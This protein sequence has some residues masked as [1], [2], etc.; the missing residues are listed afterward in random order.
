MSSPYLL[1]PIAF[2][3]VFFYLITL[4]LSKLSVIQRSSHRKIWNVILLITFLV[5]AL[6]GLILAVQVNLKLKIPYL[7][8]ILKWHVDFGIGMT[9]VAVFHFIW[10]WSYY[11]GLFKSGKHS[12]IQRKKGDIADSENN[13]I[14][15]NIRIL[16]YRFTAILLGFTTII[17]QLVLL[18]EFM[19]VFGGN[20]LIVGIILANWMIITATGAYLGKLVRI[21]KLSALSLPGAFIFLG[22]LPALTVFLMDYLKNIVFQPGVEFSAIKIVYSAAIVLIPFCLLSGFLFTSIAVLYSAASGRKNIDKI[23]ALES[24]G[25]ILA[26]LIFSYFLAG[27]LTTFQVL[28][29]ILFINVIV[30]AFMI[31]KKIPL[32]VIL[33]MAALMVSI[34]PFLFNADKIIRQYL[35]VNQDL[36][37]LKD[38]PFGN[39]AVTDYGTQQNFYENNVLLFTTEN[40]IANEEAVHYAMIQHPNPKNVLL[41]SGG[42]SG[43]TNEILKYNIKKLDYVEL[44]PWIFKLGLDYTSSLNSP[45]INIIVDDARLY[46]K[47]T[48]NRYDVIIINLPE[49]VTAQINR[50]YTQEFYKDIKK[51][52]NPDGIV[53]FSL[54]ATANYMSDKAVEL[55]STIYKTVKNVFGHVLVFCGEKNYFVLSDKPLQYNITDLFEKKGIENSYVNK[56]YMDD[57]LITQRSNYFLS[58]L[59]SKVK[60]NRDFYPVS[61]FNQIGLWLSHFKENKTLLTIVFMLL[62]MLLILFIY[63][64]HP[65]NLGMFTAG[66]T[67]SSMEILFILVFQVIYGY[68]YVVMGTFFAVFMAG[69]AIGTWTRDK[70]I[71][72]PSIR[73]LYLLQILMIVVFLVSMPII[74]I[75]KGL[76]AYKTWVYIICFGQIFII[77]SLVGI[78]FSVATVMHKKSIR[79]VAAEVYSVD[80]IGSSAGAMITAT[81]LIPLLGIFGAIGIISILSVLTTGIIYLKSNSLKY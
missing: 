78:Y 62:L 29:I 16:P 34:T 65:A 10:H 57:D 48:T 76:I 23:Y 4:L 50:Y 54:P 77:A 42:I 22:S 59:K 55:N 28:G 5:T 69:L 18:R 81:L 52:L 43:I 7:K 53:S 3:S 39:L 9:F 36:T 68:I 56:Y 14:P 79:F 31:Q 30:S 35:F 21:D 51:I 6:L 72:Q 2:L 40:T 71:S 67:A 15:E 70:I 33:V 47:K 25:S 61:Y 20:E 74:T 44:N 24:V 49:P 12:E 80:L 37:Y 41:I 1:L 27:T 32:R 66:F 60:M 11:T 46:V 58:S 38:T 64:S 63:K 13:V 19:M 26:G 73:T 75:L 8:Q 17:T 45:K